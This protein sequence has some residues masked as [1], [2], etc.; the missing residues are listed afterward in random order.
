MYR[1]CNK[2]SFAE[3]YKKATAIF[4]SGFSST[5]VSVEKA[6]EFAGSGGIVFKIEVVHGKDISSFSTI[7]S[8]QEILLPP[9]AELF[10]T[11]EATP[12]PNGFS[13]ITLLEK[14]G[15]FKW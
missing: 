5:S 3:P 9:N 8:E 2:P 4:W 1:G 7:P 12:T 14:A 15:G 6:E 11:T 13:E 10:V